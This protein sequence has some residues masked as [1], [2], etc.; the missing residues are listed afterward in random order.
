MMMQHCGKRVL[1]WGASP[2]G[3]DRSYVHSW[4]RDPRTTL[5]SLSTRYRIYNHVTQS[6]PRA[7]RAD[8][9]TMVKDWRSSTLSHVQRQSWFQPSES[10][11]Q[12]IY[13]FTFASAVLRCMCVMPKQSSCLARMMVMRSHLGLSVRNHHSDIMM[14]TAV[15]A[16]CQREVAWG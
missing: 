5:L 10:T 13:L 11:Y 9:S 14:L 7:Q 15:V 6:T 8:S 16:N 3:W 12:V 1:S 2:W 4:A